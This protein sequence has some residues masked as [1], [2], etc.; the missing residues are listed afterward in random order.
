VLKGYFFILAT[1]SKY[2]LKAHSTYSTT[3][4]GGFVLKARKEKEISREMKLFGGGGG[5]LGR[6]FSRAERLD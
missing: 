6:G 4:S 3:D 1:K 5:G 2:F